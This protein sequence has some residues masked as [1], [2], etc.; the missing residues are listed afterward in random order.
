MS[1][2]YIALGMISSGMFLFYWG[3]SGFDWWTTEE[4]K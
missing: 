3:K 1:F 4:E 2:I